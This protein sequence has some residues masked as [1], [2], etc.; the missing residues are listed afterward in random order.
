MLHPVARLKAILGEILLNGRLAVQAGTLATQRLDA[1][2]HGLRRV[3]DDILRISRQLEESCGAADADHR[4][5]GP[6]LLDERLSTYDIRGRI[7]ALAALLSPQRAQGTPKIRVGASHDG[8]YVML[9]DW[10]G[11][12][13]ALSIGIGTDDSWDRAVLARGLPVA[14]FDHTIAAPPTATPG[15]AWLPLGIGT[16][17]LNNL[18][19]LRSMLALAALPPTGDL[20]L[21]LD[22]EAAEWP[23]LG[24]YEAAAPLGRF[25]QIVIELHWFERVADPDWFAVAARAL[26]H[27]ASTHAVV[28]VHANNGG[29]VALLGGI[30]FPRVLEVTFARRNA[31]AFEP[32]DGPF[33]TPLDTPCNPVRPDLFLGSFRFPPPG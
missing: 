20:L 26:G 18:R 28:H 9:D 17:D 5:A 32:E 31:Y 30:C 15:L 23:A 8:G 10:E 3:T 16:E 1:L 21:K 22:A 11:L 7:L 19:T 33:P 14:Q 24:C 4:A 27:I 13:G 12:A 25:R 2:E 6:V 29:G